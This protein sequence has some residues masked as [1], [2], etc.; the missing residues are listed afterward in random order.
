MQEFFDELD[1][2]LQ[3]KTET[4]SIRP[5]EEELLGS[6]Q[7]FEEDDFDLD[8]DEGLDVGTGQVASTPKEKTGPRQHPM[9]RFPETKF[10]L[11]TLRDGYTR[12]IP[13]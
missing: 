13:I 3:N 5:L 7:I 11:P 9:S 6:E 12:V 8:A 2:E 10:Y 1:G 4:E